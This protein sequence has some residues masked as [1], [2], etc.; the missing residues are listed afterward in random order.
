MLTIPAVSLSGS[1]DES[2]L[3]SSS[4]ASG[5]SDLLTRFL[6]F[7]HGCVDYVENSLWRREM[8]PTLRLHG[9]YEF[10]PVPSQAAVLGL[11]AVWADL[12]KVL[13]ADDAFFA[14]LD[15]DMPEDAHNQFQSLKAALMWFRVGLDRDVRTVEARNWL[16]ALGWQYILTLA[17]KRDQAAERLI[18]GTAIVG[19]EGDIVALPAAR[20]E[21]AV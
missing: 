8:E 14:L 10:Q 19:P 6:T 15:P 5:Y 1:A 20:R 2:L 7:A 12:R 13:L 4:G 17:E 18:A 21:D 3:W 11:L 16:D 9:R